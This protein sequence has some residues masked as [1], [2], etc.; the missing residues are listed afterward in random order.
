MKP[1]ILGNLL[2]TKHT[3]VLQYI[4]VKVTKLGAGLIWLLI[5]NDAY[6][7]MVCG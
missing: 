6:I 1:L 7:S 5:L 3:L 2:F 4:E